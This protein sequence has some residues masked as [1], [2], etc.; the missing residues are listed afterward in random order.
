MTIVKHSNLPATNL[1]EFKMVA[2]E[3][4][5][6]I[7]GLSGVSKTPWWGGFFERLV[8]SVTR[9]LK[10]VMD[11]QDYPMTICRHWLLKSREPSIHK[12]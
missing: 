2:Q 9:C 11:T 10:K 3:A 8:R 5:L 4:S 6:P 7:E 12:N 1:K